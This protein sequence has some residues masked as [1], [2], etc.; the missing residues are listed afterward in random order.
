MNGVKR[1]ARDRRGNFA[2]LMAIGSVPLLL[3]GGLA[4]DYSALSKFRV[5]LQQ[6]MDSAALAVAR[7]GKRL[8]QDAALDLAMSFLDGNFP[9]AVSKVSLVREG[10]GVTVEGTTMVPLAFSGLLGYDTWPV[11]TV[12]SADIAQTSYEIALVLDTTGSMKGGK[13][14]AMKEAVDGLV[15][16]MSGQVSDPNRLKFAVVPFANF[17][18]VGP[19][20]GP[21]YDKDGKIIAGSAAPWLDVDGVTPIPQLE[22]EGISRFQLFKH[23]GQDWKGCVETRV[24]AG[25]KAHDTDDTAAE[26]GDAASLFVPAFHIDE[27]DRGGYAN[28]YIVSP[29]DP[30]DRSPAGSGAK[31]QKYGIKKSDDWTPVT[32]DLSGGKGPNQACVTQPLMPLGNN[33]ASIRSKVKSLAAN[34]TTN[35]MEGVAWGMRVLSSGEPFAQ[36]A[37]SKKNGVEKMMIVLTDGANVFGN[38]NTDLG[39]SYASRGYLKDGRLGVTVANSNTTNALMNKKTLE[40]CQFAKEKGIEVFTIRLEEP[41]VATGTMLQECATSP[42][43]YF[44]APSRTQLDEVFQSI[45]DR[46]VRVRISS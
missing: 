46:I 28:S 21:R 40:A 29:V 37:E 45:N 13:L 10:T 36:G 9:G 43:H 18:N 5:E 39:S 1:F 23:L 4:I 33:Y 11:R 20:H 6:A 2:M 3:A 17:V 19:E 42:A 31:L 14:L 15:T 38:N 27:P 30:L 7:E 26:A 16:T 32:T 35:I 25:G 22:L 8:S 24:A 41:D 44:D 12:S 34:G